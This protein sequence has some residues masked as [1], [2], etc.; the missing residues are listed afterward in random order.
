MLE[1]QI[2]EEDMAAF[3]SGGAPL[4]S[5]QVCAVNYLYWRASGGETP[6]IF[7]DSVRQFTPEGQMAQ[8]CR[9]SPGNPKVA[10]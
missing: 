2:P 9:L 6:F 8:L 10:A 7:V 5:E 3:N 1:G 4:P